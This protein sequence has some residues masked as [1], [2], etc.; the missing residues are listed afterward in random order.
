[1]PHAQAE[2]AVAFYLEADVDAS[3]VDPWRHGTVLAHLDGLIAR[4]LA[5]L[6]P[7]LE[8]EV[9]HAF[10]AALWPDAILA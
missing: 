1:M 6:Q 7:L 4:E 2:N 8:A 10:T 9:P 5:G 3:D